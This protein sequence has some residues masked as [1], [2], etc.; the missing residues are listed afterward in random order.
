MSI[1]SGFVWW[2]HLCGLD[3]LALQL[4]MSFCSFD[5]V[6]AVLSDATAGESGETGE[7]SFVNGMEPCI[8]WWCTKSHMVVVD[9]GRDGSDGYTVG[10]MEGG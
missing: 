7:P 1:A 2:M 6:G 3:V 4:E 9:E 5:F 10:S 8:D